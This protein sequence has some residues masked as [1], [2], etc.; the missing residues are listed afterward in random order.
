MNDSLYELIIVRKSRITDLLIRIFM[1][2][3]TLAVSYVTM[4]LLGPFFILALLGMILVSVLLVFPCLNVEFE[5]A[6]LNHDLEISVIYNKQRRKKKLEFDIQDA[7]IIAPLGSARLNHYRAAKT[8]NFSSGAADASVY[9]VFVPVGQTMTQILIEPDEKMVHLMK[10]W[11]G[12][13]MFLD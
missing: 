5:Y 6:L 10:G 2:M 13:K 4:L 7:E 1:I 11:M 3:A 12:Q 8:L 9:C